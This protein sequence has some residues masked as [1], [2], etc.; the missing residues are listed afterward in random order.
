MTLKRDTVKNVGIVASSKVFAR[1][2]SAITLV[3]LARLLLPSDF[4]IVAIATVFISLLDQF[5]NLG[6]RAAVIQ[7]RNDTEK[8]L[9]TG[10]TIR[11]AV[12]L[13]L[14]IIAFIGAPFWASF[15]ENDSLTSVVRVI[16]F[17]LVLDAF[18]FFPEVGLVKKLDFKLVAIAEII[19]RISYSLVAIILALSGF[20]Y[21]SIV[22]GRIVQSVVQ[23]T[24]LLIYSPWKLSLTFDTKI[25]KE[26]VHFGKYVFYA[27]IMAFIIGSLDNAVIGKVIGMSALGYYSI[28]FRWATMTTSELYLVTKQVMLPTYS[29][30]NTDIIKMRRAYLKTLKYTAMVSVPATF[31][32]FVLAPEFVI[33]VLGEKWAPAILPLRILCVLSL[34]GAFSGSTASV[35][36]S[37]GKP[38]ISA[39][40]NLMRLSA[41]VIFIVPVAKLYGIVGVAL[42]LSSVSMVLSPIN[43]S[44]LAKL[45]SI[46]TKQYIAVLA[47][48]LFS[49][50][51]MVVLTLVLKTYVKTNFSTVLAFSWAYLIFLVVFAVVV[52]F[53]SLF[54]FTKGRLKE[55]ILL[56]TS[57]LIAK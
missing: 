24:I 19:G 44:I 20:S 7:S 29:S 3:I 10:F 32:V 9:K 36:I 50:V 8:V 18:R 57:N 37:I 14:F 16:S 52:Y 31:G 22:Y 2:L 28:A 48:P 4:G 35:Y 27:G 34:F 46:R 26:L 55:D 51:I 45:L 1:V 38:K 17:I 53:I 30:I 21:W 5:S 23:P 42:L 47:P 56:I 15:Y 33:T 54:I 13:F 25:A 6:I 41:L 12:S 11:F 40:L 49:S 39:Y 43:L